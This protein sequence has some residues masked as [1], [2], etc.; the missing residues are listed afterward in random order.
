[1]RGED[2]EEDE[3]IGEKEEEEDRVEEERNEEEW[4]VSNG[5]MR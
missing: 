3:V 5:D 4:T 2:L 1:L